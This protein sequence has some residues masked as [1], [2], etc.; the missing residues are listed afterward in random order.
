MILPTS[1]GPAELLSAGCAF[2]ASPAATGGISVVDALSAGVALLLATLG[3]LTASALLVY[4]P[5]KLARDDAGR[6]LNEYL[7]ESESEYQVVARLLMIGGVVAAALFA[8]HAVPDH[9]ALALAGVVVLAL[10][11]CGVVPALFAEQRAERVLQVTIPLLRPLR[12]MLRWV[13]VLPTL[14][15]ARFVLRLL[16]VP[17]AA[18]RVAEPGEI[19]G[20]ILAAVTDSAQE[21][22][23]PDEERHWIENIVELKNRRASEIATPRT[24]MVAL[25][26]SMRLDAAIRAAA[27]AG[28]SRYPVYRE[29]I[30]EVVGVFYA[31]DALAL[32]LDPA[33]LA[34]KTVGDVCRKP[35]YVPAS[36][37][38][39]DLLRQLRATKRQ[40]ALVL[41]EYGGISGLVT[42]EDVLEEIVGDIEDEYDPTGEQA[43]RVLE[44]GR[45]IEVAGRTRVDEVNQHLGDVIPGDES[46]ET[47]AGW[48]FASLDRIPK[49][50]EVVQVGG[51]EVRIVEADNRRIARLRLALTEA[52]PLEASPA[53]GE[54]RATG[55]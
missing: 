35:L 7:G 38:V 30:D 26:A 55:S 44:A 24:D 6:G 13:L 19:A 22:S 34:T 29:R 53:T 49:K 46:Y 52:P 33:A 42:I 31:K 39:V 50:G 5:T 36:I 32:A 11:A 2:Q 54:K 37:D 23:L 10:P 43:I 48:V 16:R 15:A 8:W 14:G 41:D 45:V 47:V 12:L 1:F 28:F 25:P 17:D 3:A 51:V 4:S 40:L 18:N 9:H 27:E 21:T 20:D